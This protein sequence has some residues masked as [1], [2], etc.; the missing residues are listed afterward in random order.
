MTAAS[1]LEPLPSLDAVR[2]AQPPELRGMSDEDAAFLREALLAP[3]DTYKPLD[4]DAFD[5]LLAAAD[6]A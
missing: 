2:A 1:P 3:E 6:G 5:A 4:W